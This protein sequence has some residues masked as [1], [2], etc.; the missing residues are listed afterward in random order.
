MVTQDLRVDETRLGVNTRDYLE[1]TET[2]KE[3]IWVSHLYQSEEN[4]THV[5]LCILPL[6]DQ[7]H[8]HALSTQCNCF[9]RSLRKGQKTIELPEQRAWHFKT[10]RIIF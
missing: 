4:F 1:S 7:G 10:E 5:E 3:S 2:A 9:G 6:P 8:N